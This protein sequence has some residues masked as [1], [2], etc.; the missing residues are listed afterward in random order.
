MDASFPQVNVFGLCPGPLELPQVR[1]PEEAGV[2]ARDGGLSQ[3]GLGEA[4]PPTQNRMF[5]HKLF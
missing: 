2:S 3:G 5:E 1:G 4:D